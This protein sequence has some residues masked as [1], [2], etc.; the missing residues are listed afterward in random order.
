MLRF[1]FLGCV[2]IVKPS[3]IVHYTFHPLLDDK[4][5]LV[6]TFYVKE[7]EGW[8]CGVFH[9]S[10]SYDERYYWHDA[11]IKELVFEFPQDNS[12]LFLSKYLFKTAKPEHNY[13][14]IRKAILTV[15][16]MI[17]DPSKHCF[18][19]DETHPNQVYYW[20]LMKEFYKH[21]FTHPPRIY[22]NATEKW[23]QTLKNTLGNRSPVAVDRF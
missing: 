18:Y 4:N 7:C 14:K 20:G 23:R 19:V 17:T 16:E 10:L 2:Y 6:S 8:H 22:N 15:K 13:V 11:S 5:E 1:I 3:L 21:P 9:S 12:P